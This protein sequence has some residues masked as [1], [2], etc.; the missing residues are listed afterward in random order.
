MGFVHALNDSGELCV[1]L[2]EF[3]IV[4]SQLG[5]FRS[6]GQIDE[7]SRVFQAFGNVELYRHGTSPDDTGCFDRR[8]SLTPLGLMRH[9]T[10]FSHQEDIRGWRRHTP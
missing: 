3:E 7:L 10:D 1:M 2:C 4:G 5:I 9:I 6:V 8:R